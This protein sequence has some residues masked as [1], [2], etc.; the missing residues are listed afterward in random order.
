MVVL[1]AF[2][3]FFLSVLCSLWYYWVTNLISLKLV[4]VNLSDDYVLGKSFAINFSFKKIS[5]ALN[6]VLLVLSWS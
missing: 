6:F 4:F 3:Q 1:I 5:K 2:L